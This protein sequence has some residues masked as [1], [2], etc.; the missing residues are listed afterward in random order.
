MNKSTQFVKCGDYVFL[1]KSPCGADKERKRDL[2][3][4]Q[5]LES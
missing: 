4:S 3:S 1:E 5:E 2:A